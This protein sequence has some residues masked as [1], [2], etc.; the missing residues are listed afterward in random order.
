[1][2]I[3]I[4]A[5]PAC[6]K[7]YACNNYSMF[8]NMSDSD[9][10]SF[11]RTKTDGVRNPNFPGNYISHIK[12][13][14]KEDNN[15]FIFVSSH[16]EVRDMMTNFNIDFYTIY[17]E[18]DLMDEWVDRMIKRGNDDKFISFITN[19]WDN[20]MKE[21]ETGSY[22]REL[23]RLKSNEYIDIHLLM[24]LYSIMCIENN[25]ECLEI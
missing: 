2:A 11:S 23:I 8:F 12:S 15:H 1:M 7:T 19:N 25:V 22:G 6:G 13:L 3:V 20:F 17:P 4:S 18:S 9:S 10:S 21:I 16:K 24:K 5:F 14:I